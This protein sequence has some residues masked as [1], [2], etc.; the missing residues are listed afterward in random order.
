MLLSSVLLLPAIAFGQQGLV[1]DLRMSMGVDAADPDGL[2]ALADEPPDIRVLLAPSLETTLV[3]PMA[4]RVDAVN[5]SLGGRFA[6]GDTLVRF[7]CDEQR[8]RLAM[9]EA[10]AG[11]AKENH[12]A[13]QRMQALRQAGEVEV[14]LAAIE[15]E[16]TRAQ[17]R[18]HSVQVG[19][20]RVRAPF[21]GRIAKVEVQPYQGVNLAEPLL[22][23]VS[24]G[25]LKLRLNVPSRWLGWLRPGA[26]FAVLIDETDRRYAA[27]VSA[28]NARVDAVSQTIELEGEI[29]EEAPELLP[30][31][32]G[33][34]QFPTPSRS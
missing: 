13:K 25:P 15:V 1:D 21:D 32:S 7:D 20:C 16:R 23:I 8:A 11:A 3:S 31:M 14:A 34:A 2:A 19:H 9:A 33:T 28:I 18:M 30:G 5:A 17:V 29:V 24:N 4:G 27:K 6:K 22:E 26:G 12:S 10:E